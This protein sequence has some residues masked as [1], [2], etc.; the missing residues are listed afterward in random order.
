MSITEAASTQRSV[1]SVWAWL[2]ALLS[3]LPLAFYAYIGSFSRLLMDDYP[4]FAGALW[5]GFRDNLSYWWNHWSG[6]YTYY[7]FHDLL[8]IFGPVRIPS[9]F[10][11]VIIIVWLGGLAWLISLAL[12]HFTQRRSHAPIA[13]AIAALTVNAALMSF[14]T[15]ES[16]YWYAASADYT[17]PAGILL[18]MLAAALECSGRIRSRGWLLVAALAAGLAGFVNAGFTELHVFIQALFF[19][20]MLVLGI[21]FA[22]GSRRRAWAA[23]LF[24]A[25]LG[26][27][28][29]LALQ[30]SAPGFVNRVE[31]TVTTTH[32][33]TPLLQDLPRLLGA[34]AQTTL[35]YAGHHGSL[36]GFTLLLALGL[37]AA[38]Q[39]CK[40]ESSKQP[41][42]S[43]S[44]SP[45]PLLIALL[46]QLIFLPLL[47][48][49]AAP[50]NQAADI[51]AGASLLLICLNLMAIAAMSL[52][53]WRR[54]SLAGLLNTNLV[55]LRSLTAGAVLAAF[56]LLAAAQLQALRPAQSVYLLLCAL[57][58]L[59]ILGQLLSSLCVDDRAREL[60][61]CALASLALA[62]IAVASMAAAGHAGIGHI[63]A[64]TFTF[65]AFMQVLPGLLWGAYL[66]RLIQLCQASIGAR[67]QFPA[68][69]R[70]L[71]LGI[72]L[73]I[74]IFQLVAHAR[75][76]PN[77]ALYASE[78]DAR[79]AY[80]LQARD[81]GSRDIEVE[82][83]AFDISGILFASGEPFQGS[84]SYFY[85]VDSI[86]VLE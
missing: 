81:A 50:Q 74:I 38:L 61:Y 69:L 32:E 9:V 85:S 17:L 83:Y 30:V 48:A 27:V 46:G 40:P 64:R 41:P 47:W 52:S 43:L 45:T 44:L 10:P 2:L 59:G 23:L 53:L 77:F 36:A 49:Q 20:L 18:W 26:S 34:T 79:H 22:A 35:D 51:S 54:R 84:S 12:R 16:I 42:G 73:L 15:W 7:I 37:L 57:S 58:L 78:W 29:S 11:T 14:H 76:V 31:V 60:G 82:P 1:N 25:W 67:P 62:M 70:A 71:C 39:L 68:R 13:I 86:T 65:A 19:P 4:I 6:S 56:A 80:I 55:W 33:S 21:G 3:L 75:I 5:L 8:S 28:I 24:S 66:G 63:Y 72:I